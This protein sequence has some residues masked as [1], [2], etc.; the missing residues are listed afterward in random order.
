MK[1]TRKGRFIILYEVYYISYIYMYS[2]DDIYHIYIYMTYIFTRYHLYDISW[3]ASPLNII[4]RKKK[5]NMKGV[6]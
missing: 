5:K 1:T 4:L 2:L 6:Y 3:R